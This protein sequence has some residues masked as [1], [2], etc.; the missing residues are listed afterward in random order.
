MEIKLPNG[1]TLIPDADF[2]KQAGG[3]TDRT[4]RSWDQLG[5]PFIYIGN[6]KFRPRD[7]G[8]NWLA[9]RI[10]QRNPRRTALRAARKAI[11]AG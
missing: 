7:A 6:K 1:D 8:L 3:V 2:L 10:Q 5:C 4:G 11:A 9:S